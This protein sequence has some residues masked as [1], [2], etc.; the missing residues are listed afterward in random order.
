[1]SAWEDHE[2]YTVTDWQEEVANGDTRVGYESW[3]L[4]RIIIEQELR[5]EQGG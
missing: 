3:R 5:K 1:M 2:D 4:Q